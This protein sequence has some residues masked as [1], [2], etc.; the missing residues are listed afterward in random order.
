MPAPTAHAR[1]T[2][3]SHEALRRLFGSA[4]VS[5]L[6]IWQA[7]EA[8]D[9]KQRTWLLL[10]TSALKQADRCQNETAAQ[11]MSGVPAPS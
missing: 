9:A 6:T 3:V 8:E 2:S 10:D 1:D 7:G 4:A 11:P 5:A